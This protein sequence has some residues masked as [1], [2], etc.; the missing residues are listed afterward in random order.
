MYNQIIVNFT[1]VSLIYCCEKARTLAMLL[2]LLGSRSL[3]L[4]LDTY[5][6]II[7]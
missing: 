3:V 4:A 1:F 2:A 6:C 5:I 7:K